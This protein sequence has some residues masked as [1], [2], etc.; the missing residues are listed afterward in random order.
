MPAVLVEPRLSQLLDAERIS[1]GF[2]AHTQDDAVERLLGPALG[3]EG[4]S[5]AG[6]E[7]ALEAIRNRERAG[8]TIVGNVALPHARIA[9]LR[10][11]VV[12]MGLNAAGVYESGPLSARAVLAF[13]SPERAT[14]EH[15]RFLAQVAQLFRSEDLVAELLSAAPQGADAVLTILRSRER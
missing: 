4:F 9:G 1:L 2:R 12:A 15:L 10:R 7:A 3:R 14:V 11:I 13:A 5:A 6:V 8:S